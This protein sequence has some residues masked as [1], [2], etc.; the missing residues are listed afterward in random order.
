MANI[1][2]LSEEPLTM[3]E[4]KEEV[5]AIKKR[6][7]EINFRTGKT[8][9]YLNQFPGADMKKAEEIKNKVVALNIPR[10]KAEHVV[11][12]IDLM[13]ASEDEVKLIFQGSSLT[14]TNEN[15]K[16]IAEIVKG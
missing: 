11:K 4:L 12:I 6:D 7:K 13:P 3:A 15:V 16:K 10:I 8:E 5:N 9:E 1:K 2:I 14:L